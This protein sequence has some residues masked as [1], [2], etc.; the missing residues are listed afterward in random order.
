MSLVFYDVETTGLERRFDQIVHFAAIYT[1]SSLNIKDSVEFRC[2]VM[3]QVIPS[4]KAMQ[5][6]GRCIDDLVNTSL[7]SHYEMV[8]DIRR[9]L[10]SWS[11]ALFLGFNSLSF[12]EEFLRQAFYVSLYDPFL[13]NTQRN[14]R[15]DVLSLCRLTAGLEPDVLRQV[16]DDSG[17]KT[18]SLQSIAKSNGIALGRPHNAMADAS[19]TLGISKIVRDRAPRIWSQFLR[20]SRKDSV[21]TFLNQEDAFVFS[22]M[23]ENDHRTRVLMEIGSDARNKARRFCLDV[24]AD[25]DVLKGMPEEGLLRISNGAKSPI[26]TIRTNAAPTLWA[27]YEVDIPSLTPFEYEAEILDRA[28]R[29]RAD[30]DLLDKLQ[31]VAQSTVPEYKPSPHLEEQ[32]YGNSF[33]SPFDQELMQRFHDASWKDRVALAKDFEDQKYRRL[34]LRLIYFERPD[35]LTPSRRAVCRDALCKR[36]MVPPEANVPWRSIPAAQR[37]LKSLLINDLDDHEALG[38]LRFLDYLHERAGEL[39]IGQRG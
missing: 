14:A 2:R 36:L 19:A 18:L 5:V 16:V 13:T 37:N 7:P 10:Q 11:P 31:R 21:E 4:P 39:A 33:P 25:L 29:A 6:T 27:L 8:R 34:A 22:E 23:V 15:A 32:I 17:R 35:L 1:D 38:H 20:F 28:R 3:P 12:D 9:T 26:V 30:G 24:C